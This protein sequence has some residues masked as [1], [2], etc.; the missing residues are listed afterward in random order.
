M[1]SLKKIILLS[2][3]IAVLLVTMVFSGCGEN[4]DGLVSVRFILNGDLYTTL[5]TNKESGYK[6]TVPTSPVDLTD[7]TIPFEFIGWYDSLEY[8]NE[9]TNDTVFE[10]DATV[11]AK[12]D[13]I[14]EYVVRESKATITGFKLGEERED[15][16]IPDFINA[17]PVE[18]VGQKAFAGTE[19]Q[20]VKIEKGVL[21][22]G[23]DAFRN[24][25]SLD[26][27]TFEEGSETKIIGDSAFRG[28]TALSVID[29]PSSVRQ[30][31]EFVFYGC[32]QIPEKYGENYSFNKGEK[33][34]YSPKFTYEFMGED[35]LPIGG[36]IEPSVGYFADG[37]TIESVMRD[38]V[39]SGTNMIISIRQLRWGT[40]EAHYHEMF[41]YLEK[42]GG[43]MLLQ[44]SIGSYSDYNDV[45]DSELFSILHDFADVYPS[46][47]GLHIEDE[48]GISS[49]DEGRGE[50]SRYSGKDG[51]FIPSYMQFD[52][53]VWNKY[54]DRKLYYVN[55]LPINSPVKAFG[56][57]A[58]NYSW[59]ENSMF[60]WEEYQKYANYDYYYKTY[61]DQV[62]P[63][64]FSYDFYPLWQN[65]L[66]SNAFLDY[67]GLNGR[68][69]EQLY[70]TRYYAEDYSLVANGR[71]TPFW[72]FIQ[73][74]QWG[75]KISGSR[76]STYS[77]LVWQINTAFAFGSK[78]YQY[79]VFTDYGDIEGNGA[80][81]AY[82]GTTPM[83]IDGTINPE[84]YNMVLSA[85]TQSQAMAK[86]LLNANVDHL[87]Q[88]GA[89]P[90]GETIN[91]KMFVPRDSSMDWRMNGSSGVNHLVSCMKYY[92]NNNDYVEGV[93]GDVRELYFVCNNGTLSTDVGTY[94]GNDGEITI[95]F[96][97][98]V[99]GSYI[100]G[101]VEI[102][103][104]G[105][106]LTVDTVAGEAFAILLDK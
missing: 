92:A 51:V 15:L 86:W 48:P 10:S 82:A 29:I 1:K 32:K 66:G 18:R 5:T 58:E 101:G 94:K 93:P 17:Y 90:N 91:A 43:M 36:Y 47:A 84:Y 3:C 23:D 49:W 45:G 24:C 80:T 70:A 7:E 20:T 88:F 25:A 74:A 65:G 14:F 106:T 67:P 68:H 57:G 64:V 11:Y 40:T 28:A 75:D 46:F 27:V 22:I 54:F 52:H 77:E 103:F 39:A 104:S 85:N 31:G 76:A 83:N 71:Y 50:Y 79:F 63:E 102:P 38:W 33:K 26:M 96:D 21:E 100:Y 72:N 19:V 8:A 97:S 6:V 60:L 73:I 69:F 41:K 59:F 81:S 2:L 87:V 56:F 61:I 55:L 78:G 105:T 4:D 89:N 9:V 34:Y 99:S 12:T 30:V 42:Y 37:V 44:D 98:E 62:K 13:S 53:A 16:V 95:N 35:T